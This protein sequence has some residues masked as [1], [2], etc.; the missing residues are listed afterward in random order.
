MAG[1]VGGF[2]R[3]FDKGVDDCD[4]KRGADIGEVSLG[5]IELLKLI[6]NGCFKSREGEVEGSLFEVG[7]G[8]SK[9]FWV[10]LMGVIFDFR[11]TRI[12]QFEH[13]AYLVESFPS[14]IVDGAA[15]E[16]VLSVFLN[17]D[18]HGV[19]SGNDKAEV[20]RDCSFSEER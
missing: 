11:T 13:A 10:A 19:P 14:S 20:S 8:K 2:D 18:K 12:G 7:A 4:L 1:L 17:I 9:G 16:S 5:I 6:K 3:F 15:D